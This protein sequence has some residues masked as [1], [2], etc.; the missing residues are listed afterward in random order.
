LWLYL[1]L[2]AQGRRSG[3]GRDRDARRLPCGRRLGSLLFR[4]APLVGLL[5]AGN[6]NAQR[7]ESRRNE[8]QST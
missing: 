2:R 3:S 6:A 1:R 8:K 4:V 5:G 7:D